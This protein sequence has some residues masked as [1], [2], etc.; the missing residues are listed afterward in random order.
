MRRM[1]LAG[2]AA[3]APVAVVGRGAAQAVPDTV[4]LSLE[5]ALAR[6]DR[7]G[8]EVRL[9]RSQAQAASSRVGSARAA[10]FPQLSGTFSY[11]KTFRSVFQTGG[12]TL[13]DSLRFE[14]DPTGTV[15]ERLSYLENHTPMAAFGALGQLFGDLPF[16]RENLYNA[17]LSGSQLLWAGGRV[18]AGIALAQGAAEVAGYQ[19]D[20]QRSEIALQVE[21]A[22]WGA[23]LAGEFEGIAEAAV[24]QAEAF[25]EQERLRLGAGRASELDVLRAEV[26]L[27]NL[28]PQLVQARNGADLARLNLKRLVDVPLDVPLRL[29][30]ALDA[31]VVSAPPAP[32]PEAVLSARPA[33]AAAERGVYLRDQQVRMARSAFLPTVVAQMAYAQQAYPPGVFDFDAPWRTDWTGTVALSLPLFNGGQRFA[34]LEAARAEAEQA[35]IQLAQLREGVELQYRQALSER[36]RA[37]SQIEARRRTVEQAERVH[38][39]TVLRYDRGMATALEVSAARLGLRSARTNL[40]Q[41]LADYRMAEATVVRTMGG[42][43]VAARLRAGSRP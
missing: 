20:E 6:A 9:A 42:E 39:L 8:Q 18:R 34:D 7:D 17:G 5:S 19:L 15:D 30:T 12:F 35:R 13:P 27:E 11:T 28:R 41:A 29:T 23:V 25:L 2:L 24:E 1:V 26:D 22:Y 32:A 37:R 36:D 31:D 33:L 3:L 16:G 14:P 21:Q 38:D 4:S 43:D 40:A 10:M